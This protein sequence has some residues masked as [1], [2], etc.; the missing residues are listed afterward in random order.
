MSNKKGRPP[1]IVVLPMQRRTTRKLPRDH[2]Q[3][4]NPVPTERALTNRRSN[5][6]PSSRQGARDLL[7]S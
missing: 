1:S 5:S 7:Q 4:N 3:A 6:A 2:D